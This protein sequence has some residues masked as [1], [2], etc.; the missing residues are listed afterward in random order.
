MLINSFPFCW[1]LY[2]HSTKLKGSRWFIDNHEVMNIPKE[3]KHMSYK[4]NG[5]SFTFSVRSLAWAMTDSRHSIKGWW[6]LCPKYS[7][8][9]KREQTVHI[10]IISPDFQANQKKKCNKL[11]AKKL[12][13][14]LI[15]L[16][17]SANFISKVFF[18]FFFRF[19]QKSRANL[20]KQ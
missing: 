6:N 11:K 20:S 15:F 13:S 1:L 3:I 10:Q 17:I 7:M 8:S 9:E 5:Q 4:Q 12:L 14:W 2:M 16:L 19:C 18:C